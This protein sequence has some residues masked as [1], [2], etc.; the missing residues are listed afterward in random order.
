MAVA[1]ALF[2]TAQSW[3][4]VAG[5]VLALLGMGVG[6]SPWRHERL[7]RWAAAA[8]YTVAAEVLVALW[9]SE[10]WF[11]MAAA[12]VGAAVLIAYL[13]VLLRRA[14]PAAPSQDTEA[15]F[16]GPGGETVVV[17]GK[18]RGYNRVSRAVGGT[19]R[20]FGLRARRR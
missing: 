15:F 6:L 19:A 17:G 7:R 16:T 9:L 13:F 10:E 20:F 4:V 8:S 2:H 1:A 18:I 3:P 11:L 12:P 14:D 5:V